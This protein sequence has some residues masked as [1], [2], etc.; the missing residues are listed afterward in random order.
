MI[1]NIFKDILDEYIIIYLD[2][3]LV[4]FSKVLEDHIKKVHKM[5]KYF[6]KRNLRF[7]PEKYRFHQK[8]I[9]ILRYIVGRDKVYINPQEIVSIKE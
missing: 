7:K 9:K 6:N 2:D 4:Y 3:T 8:E 5:L 1:N